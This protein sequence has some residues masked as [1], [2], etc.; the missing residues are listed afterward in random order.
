[1][2]FLR[3]TFLWILLLPYALG[4]LG[5]ASNQ[6]VLVANHGK[7]PVMRNPVVEALTPNLQGMTDSV[8]CFMTDET[9]LNL[10]ADIFNF[11]SAGIWSIGDLA[12]EASE[13]TL[14]YCW[15]IWLGLILAS[16]SKPKRYWPG[17]DISYDSYPSLQTVP[18]PSRRPQVLPLRLRP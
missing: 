14:P 2:N 16:L 4:Y 1:M 13:E 6:L 12:M 3:R 10:L 15:G 7:F 11:K 18:S 9:H 17:T 5:A 8:H